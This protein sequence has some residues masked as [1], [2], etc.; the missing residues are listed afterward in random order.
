MHNRYCN[1]TLRALCA[2]GMD[3]VAVFFSITIASSSTPICVN[4]RILSDDL[5]EDAENFFLRLTSIAEVISA[6]GLSFV[7]IAGETGECV[8]VCVCVCM[9]MYM[10]E[11]MEALLVTGL[12]GT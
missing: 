11:W 12:S 7:S 4:I 5:I 3:Y 8:C 6:S 9:H 2:A 1:T 10:H